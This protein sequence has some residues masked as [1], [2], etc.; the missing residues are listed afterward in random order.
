M[1]DNQLYPDLE[2]VFKNWLLEI[3]RKKDKPTKKTD[4]LGF[5][6]HFSDFNSKQVAVIL[7]YY[8]DVFTRLDGSFLDNSTKRLA[9]D[10]IDRMYFSELRPLMIN[11]DYVVTV[12]KIRAQALRNYKNKELPNRKALNTSTKSGKPDLQAMTAIK[13]SE[14]KQ[15]RHWG[16]GNKLE[17]VRHY[18]EYLNQ[19]INDLF[20]LE[21]QLRNKENATPWELR[22]FYEILTE[23]IVFRQILIKK[24][25]G[26]RYT[27]GEDDR[28]ARNLTTMRQ[29]VFAFVQMFSAELPG[30]AKDRFWAYFDSDN[31]SAMLRNFEKEYWK[32][33]TAAFNT[34]KFKRISMGTK[35]P[36]E[37]MSDWEA[38]LWYHKQVSVPSMPR[39]I[40]N[41]AK[42]GIILG[43]QFAYKHYFSTPKY[44]E[45]LAP[46][47]V[48]DRLKIKEYPNV[49]DQ[50][51]FILFKSGKTLS[52][53]TPSQMRKWL[54]SYIW[55]RFAVLFTQPRLVSKGLIPINKA[56]SN[57]DAISGDAGGL[58]ADDPVLSF[59]D[60][61]SKRHNERR[62][63]SSSAGL[64]LTD[65]LKP[66]YG[67]AV[68][69]K[70]AENNS[71]QED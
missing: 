33:G 5:T 61:L 62:G 10:R 28:F 65:P 27:T 35:Q 16:T 25:G 68:K 40:S 9:L 20:V 24:T 31:S 22:N 32:N 60:T 50:P 57:V 12:V 53:L 47:V 49:A 39:A 52:Q 4:A 58:N 59:A 37:E 67:D 11:A 13:A 42:D 17:S 66:A 69:K 44:R 3:E 21:E 48:F 70:V 51:S 6:Y 41:S 46:E 34:L 23:A 29:R 26:Y 71:S 1:P 38:F 30:G 54:R 63:K 15:P 36:V 55:N 43:L 64:K 19:L 2:K 56:I 7:G 45:E 14:H 8:R 18:V